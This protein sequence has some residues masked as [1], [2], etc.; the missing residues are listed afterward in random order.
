M[1][2]SSASDF[3]NY[4]TTAKRFELPSV[5]RKLIETMAVWIV[6][7]RQR[8]ALAE[9]DDHLLDDV[10]LSRE[11]AYREAARPFWKR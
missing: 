8:Q 1:S 3:T 5:L 7:R 10:G 11:Q 4:H 6:R 9:L 2:K